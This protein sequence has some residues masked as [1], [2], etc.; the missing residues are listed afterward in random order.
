MSKRKVSRNLRG[1]IKLNPL[2]CF[3]S[4]TRA[5]ETID[6]IPP[7]AAFTKKQY[8]KGFK[9]P[10]CNVCNNK[11]SFD[12]QLFAALSILT[13]NPLDGLYI[14]Q[15]DYNRAISTLSR[16]KKFGFTPAKID[17]V[18]RQSILNSSGLPIMNLNGEMIKS[19][20]KVH[21]KIIKAILYKHTRSILSNAIILI[22]RL[23][24]LSVPEFMN[25]L[26]TSLFPF[27]IVP[28]MTQSEND[29]FIYYM[30]ETETGC[31]GIFRIHQC[32]AVMFTIFTKKQ[33]SES[34]EKRIELRKKFG[35]DFE[36]SE[37]T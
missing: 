1:F 26:T 8:P 14:P 33:F 15:Y 34:K 19:L 37:W 22:K 27:A 17:S 23:P 30:K 10:A 13:A 3:C 18:R 2:C 25:Q 16:L 9:F 4:G 32:S 29:Q 20:N 7:R 11:T 12:E 6:H 21:V 35:A 5:T 24:N 31:Y 28:D 36:Y